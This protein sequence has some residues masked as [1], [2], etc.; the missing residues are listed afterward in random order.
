MH[1]SETKSEVDA[2]I[3][4]SGKRPVEWMNDNHLLSDR[5]VAAHCVWLNDKEMNTLSRHNITAVYNPISNAR[6]GVGNAKV[7]FLLKNGVNIAIGTDSAASNGNLDLF[8]DM[9]FAALMNRFDAGT[10]LDM[11]TVNAAKALRANTGSIVKGKKADVILVD[12]RQ[13]FTSP[14]D[15]ENVINNL[16]YGVEGGNVSLSIIDGMIRY[17]RSSQS[18]RKFDRIF[19]KVKDLKLF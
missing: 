10:V 6:L 12:K 17:D 11:A 4:K 13:I 2:H 14:V 18:N 8:Q 15:K 7:K 5:L 1:L 9:K 16:V 19:E 3:K